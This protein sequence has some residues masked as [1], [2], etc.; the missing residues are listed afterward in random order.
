MKELFYFKITK[1]LT[2]E[3]SNKNDKPTNITRCE[4]QNNLTSHSILGEKYPTIK[5]NN[6][7]LRDLVQFDFGAFISRL[8]KKKKKK[9]KFKEITKPPGYKMKNTSTNYSNL[10]TSYPERLQLQKINILLREVIN[11]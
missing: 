1:K 7:L 8:R 4:I 11:K 5:G 3:L 9:K 6:I 2:R 10:V